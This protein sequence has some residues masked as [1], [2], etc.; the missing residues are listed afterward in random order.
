M[1]FTNLDINLNEL[2]HISLKVRLLARS[3]IF[4]SKPYLHVNMHLLITYVLIKAYFF[5][6][7]WQNLLNLAAISV[8]FL[9]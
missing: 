3:T 7:S 2:K 6:S 4:K 5:I 1:A 9:S 8:F